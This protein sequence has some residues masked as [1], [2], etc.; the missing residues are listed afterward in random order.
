MMEILER[1]RSLNLPDKEFVVMGSAN[2]EVKGIRKAGDLDIMI[3]KD[4]FE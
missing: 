3:E 4:L 1:I 2:L